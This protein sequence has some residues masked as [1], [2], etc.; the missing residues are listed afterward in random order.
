MLENTNAQNIQ[1]IVHYNAR[2]RYQFLMESNER[3]A[4]SMPVWE[5]TTTS[6][7]KSQ[8]FAATL[9]DTNH[10]AE[11]V[12][13][14][15]PRTKQHAFAEIRNPYANQAPTPL[16]SEED[17]F[18]FGDIIDIINPL[19]HIPLVNQ[20]YRKITNDDIK[21][22]AE[23]V[24]GSIYGGATGGL[25]ALANVVSKEATG[26]NLTENFV[27]LVMDQ[28]LPDTSYSYRQNTVSDHPIHNINNALSMVE[29]QN[30]LLSFADLSRPE[31]SFGLS[32]EKE[33]SPKAQ[34]LHNSRNRY[35]D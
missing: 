22:V 31:T 26:K 24:G 19:Q 33:V 30:A 34:P 20:A 10:K 32:K 2:P 16:H 28:E 15:L 17:V 29:N 23:I 4:G 7:E 35:N 14:T 1:S 6:S 27:S 12:L 21:P 5:K 13:G 3:T 25:T 9:E 8:S 18:G 11:D